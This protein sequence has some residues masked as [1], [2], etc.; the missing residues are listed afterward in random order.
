MNYQKILQRAQKEKANVRL[1]IGT[2]II[3]NS[4]QIVDGI[5]RRWAFG[6]DPNGNAI[7]EYRSGEYKAFKVSVNPRAGGL[8]DLTLTGALGEGLTIRKLNDKRYEIFSTDSKFKKIADKYG[9][10]QFN[11]DQQQQE[12]LFDML[13]FFALENYIDNVWLV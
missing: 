9:I 11:L 1:T 8:V 12:E 5:R 2:L 7:G 4:E 13:Y 10:Q 6:K 3:F